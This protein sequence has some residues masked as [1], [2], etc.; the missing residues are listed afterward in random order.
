MF[1]DEQEENAGDEMCLEGNEQCWLVGRPFV[2]SRDTTRRLEGLI[3]L[4]CFH[5]SFVEVE[6]CV[7]QR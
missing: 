6:R 4:A 7:C 3:V 2:A 1:A 5:T